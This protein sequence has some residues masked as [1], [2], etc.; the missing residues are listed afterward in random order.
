[1]STIRER[2]RAR[3]AAQLLGL[4]VVVLALVALAA[5]G[6]LGY[7]VVA[8]FA[9]GGAA[10]IEV[11]SVTGMK[12][13]EAEKTLNELNLGLRVTESAYS[14][15]VPAGRIIKQRPSAGFK[16]REGRVVRVIQSL[17]TPSLRVP[18]VVG[19]GFTQ[20]QRA[21][22]KAGLAVGFVRKVYTRAFPR[23]Q[24]VTQDPEPGKVFTNPVKVDLT[25]A[26]S[27]SSD[28]VVMPDLRGKQLYAAEHKLFRANLTLAGVD[29][30][31]GLGKPGAVIEQSPLPGEQVPL[32]GEVRLRVQ[33][34]SEVGSAL[35]RS[36][37]VRFRLPV[38][39]PAGK[40]AIEIQDALGKQVI[41]EDQVKPGELVEQ[42][43]SVEGKAKV[44]V[45]FNGRLMRED[46]I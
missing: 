30:V 3:R 27:S 34:G 21:I 6:Y 46:T 14:Q 35:A 44:R 22:A 18:D 20:A 7:R 9:A 17:G 38:T 43:V 5:L 33:V 42:V 32:T 15:D 37:Q 12:I 23:G 28:I 13:E 39:L 36:F 8:S 19:K 16:V 26:D 1:M 2:E 40:L 24:V 41:Y 31:S 45:L 10:E 11:P 25:V 4:L 29:Y